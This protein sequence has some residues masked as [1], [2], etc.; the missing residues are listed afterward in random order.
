ML[1]P[2]T[3]TSQRRNPERTPRLVYKGLSAYSGASSI[4]RLSCKSGEKVS[5]RADLRTADL[6]R[7]RVRFG[8]LYLSRKVAWLLGKVSVAYRRV[9][10]DYS[11]ISVPVSV[12]VNQHGVPFGCPRRKATLSRPRAGRGGSRQ[13][14]KDRVANRRSEAERPGASGQRL[15]PPTSGIGL[16]RGWVNRPCS[17]A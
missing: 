5:R 6:L 8:P 15:S 11:Q 3:P 13:S 14:R 2:H 9:T 1:P 16:V 17:Y 12:S 7:L 10:P 4:L